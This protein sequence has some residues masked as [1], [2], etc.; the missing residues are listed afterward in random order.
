MVDWPGMNSRAAIILA[1]LAVLSSFVGWS[2]ASRSAEILRWVDEHGVVHFTDVLNEIPENFRGQATRMKVDSRLRSLPAPPDKASI[3]FQKRGDLIVIPATINERAPVVFVVDTG[4]S[5]TTIS[6]A[7]AKELQLDLQNN[8]KVI[9]F[10]TANGT[11]Q[12][13]IAS[14]KSIEVGGLGV[15][16]IVVAVHDIF[17]DPAVAG[18]LGLNFLSQFRVDIDSKN[19]VMNLEKK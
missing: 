12:A 9:S 6:Q 11:I 15:N 3:K 16:D 4:A 18:L 14:V 8:P 2:A 7:T 5:Y 17:P 1:A 19:G 13:P 10:Q